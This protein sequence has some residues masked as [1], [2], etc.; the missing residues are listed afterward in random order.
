M[1]DPVIGVRKVGI[2]GLGRYVPEKVLT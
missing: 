2:A 1:A